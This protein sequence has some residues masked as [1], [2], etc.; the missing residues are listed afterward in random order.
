[1]RSLIEILRDLG[2]SAYLPTGQQIPKGHEG[3]LFLSLYGYVS[4][5]EWYLVASKI[6]GQDVEGAERLLEQ[7]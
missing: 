6:Y 2:V 7:S 3:E 4:K 5:P 1:M